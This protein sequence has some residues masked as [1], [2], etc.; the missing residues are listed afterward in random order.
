VLVLAADHVYRMDYT[1]FVG[2]HLVDD[3]DLTIGAV[4]VPVAE[5]SRFGIIDATPDGTVRGFA[6]KPASPRPLPDDP[7]RAL[8]SMGIYVFRRAA[9]AAAAAAVAKDRGVDFGRDI[10]PAILA[11][12][13]R[14]RVHAHRAPVAGPG[15]PAW[16]DVGTPEA[17]LDA[18]LAVHEAGA[19]HETA[20]VAPRATVE[21]SVLRAEA[22][23]APGASVADSFILDGAII[24]PGAS[25]RRAI[26]GPGVRIPGGARLEPAPG[27]PATV[28]AAAASSSSSRRHAAW[29]RTSLGA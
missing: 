14:V 20:R 27:A 7:T 1:A 21:R 17:L 8:A 12:G 2:A 24:G 19:I 28:V 18:S 26:V 22:F 10:V 4:P 5:G 9:L 25:V 23:I 13:G 3:A 6:E 16:F 29:F 11:A 15:S